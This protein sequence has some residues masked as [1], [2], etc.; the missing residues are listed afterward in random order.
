MAARITFMNSRDISDSCLLDL[1]I[2]HKS[3]PSVLVGFNKWFYDALE[4]V[5]VYYES[6]VEE[7]WQAKCKCLCLSYYT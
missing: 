5:I 7:H 2:R 3:V 6:I 4:I 1:V